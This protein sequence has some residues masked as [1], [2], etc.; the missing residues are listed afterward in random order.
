MKLLSTFEDL[1]GVTTSGA[2]AG[3]PASNVDDEDPGLVWKADA[4]AGDVWLKVDFGVAASLSAVFLNRANFPQAKIQGHATD[5]WTSPSY[6]ATVNLVQDEAGNRK[7]WY[8][9]TAFNYRWIRILIPSGQTLDGGASLP[10]L[11][12][13]ITGT[14][15]DLPVVAEYS[16]D[17][18]GRVDEWTSDGGNLLGNPRGIR[19]HVLALTFKDTLANLLAVPKTWD[20][21][22][23]YEALGS[24]AGAF[25]VIAP[26][27]WSRPTRNPSD[28]T[29]R[30]SL[31]ERT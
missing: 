6:D 21:A 22:V 18:V 15:A 19:R 17:L 30:V 13:W 7:G 10:Q 9:L 29:L 1:S 16:P 3:Y 27:R 31:K 26:A 4:Y 28:A 25:L 14:A 24:A 2:T 8:D 12:N 11:G 5:V 23:L 20:H